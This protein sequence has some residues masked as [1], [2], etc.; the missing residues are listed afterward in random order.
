MMASCAGLPK[1]RTNIASVF[2]VFTRKR[3]CVYMETTKVLH[4]SV[5]RLCNDNVSDSEGEGTNC[6]GEGRDSDC[7]QM[8]SEGEGRDCE[9]EGSDGKS[10]GTIQRK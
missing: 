2:G 9:G 5:K 1:C 6:E 8:D 10:E 3:F 7:E 4:W